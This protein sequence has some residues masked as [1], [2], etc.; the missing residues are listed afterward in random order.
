MIENRVQLYEI[1]LRFDENGLRGAHKV[2]ITKTVD[3]ETNQVLA[4]REGSAEPVSLEDLVALVGAENAN[5]ITQIQT[6]QAHLAALQVG[7]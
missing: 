6:L 7:R 2:S 1:L 3:S 5:L 4:E